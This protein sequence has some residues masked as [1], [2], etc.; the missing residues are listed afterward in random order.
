[1]KLKF[2]VLLILAVISAC[3]TPEQDKNDSNNEAMEVKNEEIEFVYEADRFADLRIIRYQ[4][5]GW[6]NLSLDQKKLVYYLSQAGYSGR[7]IIWDQ[8]YR[9]N[10]R[11][12]NAIESVVRNYEGDKNNPEW[13]EFMTY[14]KRVWFSNGIHHHYSTD[15]IIPKFSKEYFNSLLSS[16]GFELS[17]EVLD[18]IYNPT[19]DAMKVS[20][21]SDKD[22]L[23]ASATNFYDP[24]ITEEEAIA[25]YSNIIDKEDP[26]PIS[27][28][29][30]SKLVRNEDGTISEVKWTAEG[31]Y[32]D[33]IEKI[34]SWLNKAVTVAENDKQKVALELLVEYYISGDLRKWDEYSIAWTEATEGDIDYINSFIEIYNDPLG[35]KGSYESIIQ[36]KDFDASERMKVV[37]DDIQWFEDNSPIMEEHKK[38]NVKGVSFKVVNVAAESGDASPYSSIGVNLPNANWIRVEYGSKSVSLGN[39]SESYNLASGSGMV[40]EFAYND[41]EKERSKEYSSLASKM[42]TALHEV[43]G[44]A[45]GQLNPGVGTPKETLQ[46]YASTLEEARAD[47]VAL[48]YVMDPK[49]IEMGLIPSLEVAKAE[50]DGYIRRYMM[51][52]LIRIE[53][54]NDIQE[55]HMRNRQLNASWAYEKGLSD[56]VIEKVKIDGK[57]Y[58]HINDY[59]NLRVIFGE[60]LKEIQ[61]IKSEG[62]YEA[63]KALVENYGVKVDQD[64]HAEVL[65]RSS[66]LNIPPYSGFINPD[67]IPILDESGNITDVRVEYP[68]DFTQQMLD[69]SNKYGFLRVK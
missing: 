29:L 58:F 8:N 33:A 47:L 37:A 1:M 17:D 45:S 65:E 40:D 4:I 5:P 18:A 21:D 46:N 39:I 64:L 43:V 68:T 54:G 62:D 66:E 19:M 41:E 50:Y 57:T 36:I 38:K 31:M 69:Y 10:L 3:S 61:R 48:Y 14:T 49:M 26:R 55:S 9:Y 12:R 2:F 25:F 44:H 23:L 52:Q 6:E 22:L 35:Y 24:D 27:Y 56:N 63:G 11:I 13:N 42:H 15:K 60:L 7:D 67:I 59:A 34:I 20:L 28:S 16:V 53:L 32:G 30:N 51:T